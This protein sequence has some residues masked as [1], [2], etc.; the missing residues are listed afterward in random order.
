VSR[1][2]PEIDSEQLQPALSVSDVRIG[3]PTLENKLAFPGDSAVPTI[4]MWLC[5]IRRLQAG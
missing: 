5:C 4:L 2:V 1:A 3:K